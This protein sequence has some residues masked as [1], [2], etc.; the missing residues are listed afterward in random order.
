MIQAATPAKPSLRQQVKAHVA[1]VQVLKNQ[2]KSTEEVMNKMSENM[3]HMMLRLEAVRLKFNLSVDE[4]NR[5]GEELLARASANM[6]QKKA[7][8]ELDK[9]IKD[10]QQN[11]VAVPRKPA[12]PPDAVTP[13]IKTK[14]AALS[15]SNSGV[16]LPAPTPLA[17]SEAPPV[18]CASDGENTGSPVVDFPALKGT[19][20]GPVLAMD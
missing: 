12:S 18:H 19:S 7:D 5:L 15:A 4:I 11:G 9:A 13:E 1:Q 17:S 20:A 2:I 3:T 10:A 8:E 14:L 6:D 16:G